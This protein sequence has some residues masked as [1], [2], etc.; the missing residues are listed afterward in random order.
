MV[1]HD[2]TDRLFIGGAWVS[3]TTADTIEVISPATEQVIARVPSGSVEDIDRAVAAARTAFDHGPWPRMA[4]EDRLDVLT[5]FRDLYKAS[6]KELAALI[7]DE[8]GCPI[9]TSIPV[10]AG[11]P[12]VIL[13]SYL[14]VAERFPFRTI[15]HSSNGSALVTAEPAGVVGAVVPWNVPQSVIMQKLAPALITGCTMVLKPAPETPLD[16]YLLAELLQEAGVPDGVLNLV[17]ADREASERLVSHPDVDK[18]AFTGS[19]AVG[20]RIASICGK[21]LRRVTLEL[22][23]KSAAILLDDADFESA[24]ESLRL[25]SFRNSGQ[26]CSLKTRLLVSKEREPELLDLLV[27][28]IESMPVGDPRDELTQ[29][30]PLVSA[31]HRQTVEGYLELGRS[32]GR[33]VIGGGR[34]AGLDTGWFVEPTIF[35]D[36]D[37][38]SRIAQEEVF[39]PVLTVSTFEDEREAVS[40]ANNS[41]YGLNG[42]VFTASVDHGVDIAS[43]IRTGTVEINGSPSG[44][45]APMGGFKASGIGRE[46]GLE[47]LSS[48]VETRSVGVPREYAERLSQG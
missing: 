3:P 46:Q 1:W 18:V 15:R 10:Q 12:L 20:R 11:A 8:M 19:S 30:G 13:E 28:L 38:D 33:T 44:S 17:P 29:I 41:P 43:Q 39:G 5:R 34:P 6:G 36:V 25:G 24:V 23:G 9:S 31:R 37:P 27:G 4:L 21:D 48:Y 22:G 16:A 2:K 35:A 45:Q 7:T 26:V 47:G 42:A 32:E 14:A 40:I